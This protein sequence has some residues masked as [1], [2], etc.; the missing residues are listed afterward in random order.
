[1][2]RARAAKGKH[3]SKRVNSR[4]SRGD[5]AIE[6]IRELRRLRGAED[7]E[8]AAEVED[9]YEALY[10]PRTGHARPKN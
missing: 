5:A 4:A 1:M 8:P 9:D 7:D 3:A 2:K 10:E 6:A